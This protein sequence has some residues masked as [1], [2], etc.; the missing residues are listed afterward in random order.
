MTEI[1][2]TLLFILFCSLISRFEY[3]KYGTVITPF[4]VMAWPYAIIALLVNLGGRQFGFFPVSVQSLAFVLICLI[5]FLFGG[6]GLTLILSDRHRESL[7][8]RKKGR[9]GSDLFHFYRPLFISMAWISITAGILQF[10]LLYQEY[11]LMG[12]ATNQF[13]EDYGSGPLSHLM[14]LSRPAFIF[15][16][17]DSI[18]RK[19]RLLWIPLVL[20]FLIIL[21]GQIKYHLAVVWLSAIFFGYFHGIIKLNVKKFLI[22]GVL[23][24]MI[25]NLSYTI[26][27]STFGLSHAYSAKVQAFLFNHFFTYLFGG[28]I[29]FS[30]ILKSPAFPLYSTKEIFSVPINIYRFIHGDQIPVDI[31]FHNWIPVSSIYRYFH[32]SNVFGL[33]G[34]LYA[35]IGSYGT[36]LYLFVVGIFVYGIG[37]NAKRKPGY[38]GFQMMYTLLLGYLTLSFFGLYFNML[39]FVEISL[40][41]L[42]LPIIYRGIRQLI[43]LASHWIE[44]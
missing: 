29:G 41:I 27:F 13:L 12:I 17:V 36:Y 3:Q 40:F 4:G 18:Q 16:F 6:Y 30:E 43:T 32:G 20:I 34:T 8:Y 44:I 19:K 22:Y 23:I 26:G 21:I 35:Y 11:G 2:G 37:Y 5:L 1:L 38:I 10:I 24:Y 7:M 39:S 25:F 33:F 15:L 28:P 9:S 42:I 14:L 31:I